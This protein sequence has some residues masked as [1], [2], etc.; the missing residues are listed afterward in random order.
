MQEKGQ[1]LLRHPACQTFM[2]MIVK[3]LACVAVVYLGETGNCLFVSLTAMKMNLFVLIELYPGNGTGQSLS[4]MK[5]RPCNNELLQ[6]LYFAVGIR[7][8]YIDSR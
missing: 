5:K 2:Q 7:T 4:L 6:R 1:D 8:L 3:T